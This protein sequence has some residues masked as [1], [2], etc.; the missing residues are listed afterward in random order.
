MITLPEA[1]KARLSAQVD[2][3]LIQDGKAKQLLQESLFQFYQELKT[4]NAD[5]KLEKQV[6]YSHE[7]KGY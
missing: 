4:P 6:R 5:I 3:L 7:R 1:D 2:A